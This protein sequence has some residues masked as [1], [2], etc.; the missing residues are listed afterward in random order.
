VNGAEIHNKYTTQ[1][2]GGVRHLKHLN[3]YEEHI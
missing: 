3:T 1:M 2:S